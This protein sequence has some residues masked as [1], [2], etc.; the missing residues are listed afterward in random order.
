VFRTSDI[1]MLTVIVAS[2]AFTYK[3]K[4]EADGRLYEIRKLEAQIRFE[5]DTID[6]LKADWSALTQPS[7][8]QKLAQIYDAALGLKPVEATQFANAGDLPERPLTIEDLTMQPTPE[9]LEDPTVDNLLT[10]AVQ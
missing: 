8:L 6:V 1:I 9:L 2:A 10:G 3:V 5:E 7:R 4:H